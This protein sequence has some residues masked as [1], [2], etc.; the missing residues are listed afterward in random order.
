MRSNVAKVK[1]NSGFQSSLDL[2]REEELRR[3][4]FSDDGQAVIRDL[5]AMFKALPPWAL[6]TAADREAAREN[7]RLA[8]LAR[9][10]PRGMARIKRDLEIMV[11][12]LPQPTASRV[13]AVE[14]HEQAPSQD[15]VALKAINALQYDST[16]NAAQRGALLIALGDRAGAVFAKSEA[17]HPMAA[18]IDRVRAMLE[19]VHHNKHAERAEPLIAECLE[20]IKKGVVEAEDFNRLTVLLNE[21]KAALAAGDTDAE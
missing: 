17:P 14:S 20:H 2:L 15:A 21:V 4:G 1:D 16:L 18:K 9:G 5:E 7:R 13:V 3:A 11:K 8:K 10:N 6:E 19:K 12:A